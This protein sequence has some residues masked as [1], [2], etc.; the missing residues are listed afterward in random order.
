MA[1]PN[2]PTEPQNPG[3][4][5]GEPG[6]N[7]PAPT[8]TPPQKGGGP[9][10]QDDDQVTLSKEDYNNLIGQ[11]DRSNNTI[12]Q[13]SSFIETIAQERAINQFLADNKEKYPDLTLD[14]LRYAESPE[15]L[16]KE[17]AR[18][19]RRLEDHAQ[20]KLLEIENHQPPQ[21]TPDQRAARLADLR[22]N[23]GPAS[24]LAYLED[25]LS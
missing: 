19:Q 18:V 3:G 16:E 22:K 6:S 12:D 4:T 8:A 10:T 9:A 24:H 14:D 15:D 23:P 20:A 25:K 2:Q 7:P 21:E 17:A 13:Q 1:E 5:G 11:R